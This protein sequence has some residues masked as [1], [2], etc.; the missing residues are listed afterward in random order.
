[1]QQTLLVEHEQN[2]LTAES[3]IQR[4]SFAN[5]PLFLRPSFVLPSF[6]LRSSFAYC[7]LIVHRLSIVSMEK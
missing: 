2:D 5:S 7:P 4:S 6:I 1:M 3:E